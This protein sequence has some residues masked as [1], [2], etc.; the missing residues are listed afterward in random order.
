M[1]ATNAHPF[2]PVSLYTCTIPAETDHTPAAKVLPS[3]E[4]CTE[5]CSFAFSS[6]NSASLT[7]SPVG[8]FLNTTARFFAPTAN[9]SPP[10]DIAKARP[11]MPS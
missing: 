1:V 3:L 4:R 6:S 7:Q 2:A 11:N 5:E 9:T 8:P 10:E